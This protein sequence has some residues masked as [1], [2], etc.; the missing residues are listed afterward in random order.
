[1]IT[2]PMARRYAQR[3]TVLINNCAAKCAATVST[4]KAPGDAYWPDGTPLCEKHHRDDREALT[5]WRA[6]ECKV[7]E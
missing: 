6:R 5:R 4:R 1:M 7:S 2:G 3:T